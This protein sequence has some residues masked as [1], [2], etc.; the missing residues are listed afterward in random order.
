MSGTAS[1]PAALL[2]FQRTLTRPDGADSVVG[3]L[4]AFDGYINDGGPEP[5]AVHRAVPIRELAGWRLTADVYVPTGGGPH[6]VL[7]YLHGGAWVMGAPASH[8]RLAAELCALGLVVAV[9]DYRRAPKHRF[10]AAVDDTVHALEWLREHAT[11]F[12]GDP[13]RLL[14]G[15]DSAGGNLAA[16]ALASGSTGVAAALLCYGIFDYHRAL[17][18]LIGVVGDG[19]DGQLYVQP[20]DLAVLTD[21]PRLHPERHCADFPPSL[22]LVGDGDP[23]VDES[24]ALAAALDVAGVE[25]AFVELPDAPHGFLQLP[26]IAAHDAGLEAID[27]FLRR[28]GVLGAVP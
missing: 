25:H 13:R 24:R 1:V 7:L 9:L 27:A 11:D 20:D 4:G 8:R 18:R 28:V 3:L 16:A 12:G 17:P 14:V 6:P 19:Q 22:V 2:E 21:D 5:A 23:L 15:G 26:T 10:P